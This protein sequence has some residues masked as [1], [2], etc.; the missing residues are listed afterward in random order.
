MNNLVHN[1]RIVIKSTDAECHVSEE[2]A[3]GVVWHLDAES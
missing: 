3:P 2:V 1:E